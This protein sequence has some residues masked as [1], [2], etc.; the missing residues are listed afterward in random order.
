MEYGVLKLA[1][2]L[3]RSRV[4]TMICS[5]T[6]ASE[7]KQELDPAV[8]LFE[9]RRREGNDP[10]LVWQLYRRLRRERPD[11]LHTHAWGTL[12]EG[13]IAGRLAGVPVIIHGEHGTLRTGA[14]Q[15]RV[16]RWAWN[17]VDHVVSVS[18]RLAERMAG[19]IGF[20]LERIQ[21][22]RNGVDLSRFGAGREVCRAALGFGT[23]DFVIGTA[24]RLV[25]VKD[26]RSFVASASR[27]RL[28]GLRF[29]ALIAGEGPLRPALER[30]IRESGL[31]G[32]VRLLGHRPDIQNVLAALDVF[33]L[34]STSE[35]LSNTILEAMAAGVPVVSTRVG[36]ADELVDEPRTGIL[37]PPSD[38][39]ALARAVGSLAAD[40]ARRR[41]MGAAAR[42]RALREFS[43]E[44]M[45]ADYER[46][47]VGCLARS[48]AG[49]R[50]P[51]GIDAVGE[52]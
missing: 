34:S 5:T 46:L 16:Q 44:R 20:P 50:S 18:S 32:H 43:L 52:P 51:A 27:L 24:G 23:D 13:L 33:V 35:G 17:R 8:P 40:P 30:Q 4:A 29:V 38:P 19:Q 1:N 7:L 39:A 12:C 11:V 45:L 42:Q 36:G 15:A 9:C 25:E 21:T 22:I 2:A 26:Q 28:E 47:Y 3:D 31:D 49:K 6:P 37:V 41:S 14:M 10:S 48:E